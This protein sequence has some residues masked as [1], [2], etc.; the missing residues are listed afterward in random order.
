MIKIVAAV[1]LLIAG[2]PDSTVQEPAD[3]T[4][5]DEHL[6]HAVK[7]CEKTGL[8]EFA[9]KE[10]GEYSYKCKDLPNTTLTV[11]REPARLTIT[12]ADGSEIGHRDYPKG[13]FRDEQITLR[14]MKR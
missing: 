2:L 6:A 8:S 1:V 11:D 5:C 10:G 7:T 14:Y 9:C 3:K 13:K 4:S 12:T